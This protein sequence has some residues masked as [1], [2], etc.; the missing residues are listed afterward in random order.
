M[1]VSGQRFDQETSLTV[2]SVYRL[3]LIPKGYIHYLVYLTI[4]F[5]HATN[6]LTYVS[7]QAKAWL[8]GYEKL[9]IS[10]KQLI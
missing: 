1:K 6:F 7:V 3:C 10:L 4:S 8:E 9:Y 5:K 2:Y